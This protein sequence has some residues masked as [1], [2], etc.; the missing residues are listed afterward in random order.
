[1]AIIR[2]DFISATIHEKGAELQ[3]LTASGVDYMWDGNPD[4]WGKHSPI[5]FPIVGTLK[6]NQYRYQDHWYSLSRHGFAREMVF[7]LAEQEAH[8]VRFEL[9]DTADTLAR[10]PFHFLLGV[11]YSLSGNRLTVA[12]AVTNTGAGPMYFSLGAHPAFRV[13]LVPGTNYDDYAVRFN[14]KETAGR[15]P[16]SADGLIEKRSLQLL[17]E[18]D[19]LPLTKALFA[20][21]ALVFKDLQ[22]DSV[23]L[24]SNKT[25]HGLEMDFRGF[26][27]FGIWAAT[28]ANFVCLEPWC[29][30]ADAV[31][32]NQELTAKEGINTLAAGDRFERNWSVTVH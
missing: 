2:N 11:D 24:E 9:S 10:Y 14:K 6:D 30:I 32:A 7:R 15:W 27:Y 17:E 21:D 4:V 16:I 23:T 1:M 25:T 18:N 13:P 22:S 26:P 31:D 19:T 12:Y 3:R 28:G 5:L 20:K 8:R 29:G